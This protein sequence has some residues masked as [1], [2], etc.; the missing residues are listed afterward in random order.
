MV[1]RNVVVTGRASAASHTHFDM[2]DFIARFSVG[3]EAC[4]GALA[5]YIDSST[6]F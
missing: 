4:I 2:L 6:R 1:E 3:S 5:R